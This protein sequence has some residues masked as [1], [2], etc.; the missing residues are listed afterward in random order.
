MQAIAKEV[1]A[2]IKDEVA[3][4]TDTKATH[5]HA[6][7]SLS[8]R[9]IEASVAL[10]RS[11]PGIAIP[12]TSFDQDPDLFNVLNGTVDLRTGE[13]RAH[14]R[15]DL[16]TRLAPVEFDSAASCEQ[17]DSF[18]WRIT[19]REIELYKFLQRWIGYLLTGHVTEQVLAFLVGAGA[20]GKSA[21]CHV[22]ESLL[23]EYACIVSPDLIMA[24]RHSGIPNDVARLRG[25]RLALMNE[26]SQGSRFSEAKLKDL[27]GG[28]KL[29]ARFMFH[30]FFDFLPTHRLWIR[31]NH[32]PIIS[33]TDEGIWRRLH[34]VPF[35]VE[36]PA[37]EQDRD[38]VAKLRTELSGIL[39]WAIEGCLAW[40]TE[41][42]NPPAVVTNA[43]REYREE[44]DILGQFLSER[45]EKSPAAE[46]RA[47]E[48][49]HAYK[50]FVETA[51]ERPLPLK[52]LPREMQRR[53]IS[54]K[55]TKVGGLY[56]GVRLAPPGGLL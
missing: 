53:G 30:E 18:L 1:H 43:V 33:G 41:G 7:Y 14:N 19:G 48:F 6:L 40:R 31:G 22:V 11:E 20:N 54:W 29:T 23:G 21:L 26:T 36:I 27:T 34:L 16:I 32:R 39:R 24:K 2:A 12:L 10:T 38:L 46:V 3:F 13:L 17:W 25:A 4:S 45:C 5:K 42:L 49:F 35:N 15:A 9:G 37:A 55:R 44:S 51:G 56:T 8:R 50:A 52:D 47:G 28:D